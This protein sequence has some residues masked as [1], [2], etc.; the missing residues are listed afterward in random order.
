MAQ[1]ALPYNLTDGQKAYA[2]RLM[3]NFNT[4]LN[5]MNSGAGGVDTT[6]ISGVSGTTV[7]AVLEEL[8]ALIALRYT[9]TEVDTLLSQNTDTLVKTLSINPTTGILTATLKNGTTVNSGQCLTRAGGTMTGALTLSGAP[10]DPLHAAT[11]KYV[12]ES[13]E[14]IDPAPTAHASTHAAGGSDVITPAA[15]GAIPASAKGVASGVAGLDSTGKVPSA[16]LPTYP[17]ISGKLDKSGGTMTG[18]LMLN[19]APFE[20]LHAVTKKFVED[21]FNQVTTKIWT[22]TIAEY[23]ALTVIAPD[24][25]YFIK[26]N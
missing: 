8:A 18:E 17:D 9:K 14:S 6:A 20:D 25:V 5:Q 21:K 26:E 23:D 10:T 2:S 12:D 13:I 24:T 1:T 15:I 3:A 7:Q 22:G 11:K 4:L 16:Q 19:G